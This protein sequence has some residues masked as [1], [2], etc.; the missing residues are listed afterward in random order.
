M[1]IVRIIRID[2][3]STRPVSPRMLIGPVVDTAK[4]RFTTLFNQ[5][6]GFIFLEKPSIHISE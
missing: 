3:R 6:Y 2:N 4:E 5:E 1:E